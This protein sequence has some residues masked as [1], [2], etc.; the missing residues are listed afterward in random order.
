[1]KILTG[2]LRGQKILF[3]PV[4][5][6]RPTADKVRKAIFD[7]LQ[8]QVEG[9]EILDLFSGTGAL[10]FEALSLGAK[11]VT[12]VEADPALAGEIKEHLSRLGLEGNAAVFNQDALKTLRGLSEKNAH[13]DLVFLDPPYHLGLALKTIEVLG[14]SAL[15]KEGARVIAECAKKEDLPAECGRLKQV[16]MK[17]YGDAKTVHYAIE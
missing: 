12:F 1:M 3:S 5:S 14:S 16:K 11:H 17:I 4:V 10:G 8:G 6:L 9:A 15:L 13:F 7:S 2:S